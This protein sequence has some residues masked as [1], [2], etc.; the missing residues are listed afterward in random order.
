MVDPWVADYSAARPGGVTLRNAGAIGAMRYTGAGRYDGVIITAAEYQELVNAG[1][2]VGLVMEY[3]ANWIKGGY[4]SGYNLAAAA[5]PL[6]R[7]MG[8]PDGVTYAACDYDIQPYEYATALSTMQGMADAYGGWGYVGAYGSRAWCEWVGANSP[9]THFWS[10]DAWSQYIPAANSDLHQHANWP[11]GVPYISGCDHNQVRGD[12]GPRTS[13]ME[14]DLTPE[15]HNYLKTIAGAVYQSAVQG[16]VDKLAIN[17][18]LDAIK[19]DVDA[20]KAAQRPGVDQ[21]RADIAA[22]PAATGGVTDLTPV[23]Q[24]IDNLKLAVTS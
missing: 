11:A 5:R 2:A 15:E 22:I 20:M 10:A 14:A 17:A 21:I 7:G 12:W 16:A 19:V 13:P 8:I 4:N 6:E 18:K 1:L 3:S 24:K 23:M 9:C